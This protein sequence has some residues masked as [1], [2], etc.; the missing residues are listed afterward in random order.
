MKITKNA[1]IIGLIVLNI[2]VVTFFLLM[3]P[4]MPE[5]PHGPKQMIIKK[6]A[7]DSKQQEKFETLV[8]EHRKGMKALHEDIR[9]A[10]KTIYK[11][12]L[13]HPAQKDSL[14]NDL[15][16]KLMAVDEHNIDHLLKIKKMLKED[17]MPAFNKM[18]DN[19]DRIFHPRPP[20][21]G[22]DGPKR[23]PRP[24]RPPHNN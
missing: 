10:K 12:I 8:K 19:I 3:K 11:D 13:D 21:P 4:P 2:A 7:L 15:S 16:N 9:Q 23:P 1:I 17:Q 22:P 14:L 18:V 5:P 20:K 6:L 24:H